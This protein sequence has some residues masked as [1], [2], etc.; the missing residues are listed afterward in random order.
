MAEANKT[1][2]RQQFLDSYTALVNGISTARFDEFKDFFA[3][4][5][6]FE[7]AV[8]EFRDGLQQELLAKVNRLWNECDIDTNVEILESLK[9]KAA[10]SS[11]KM[12]RPTGK[13]VSEQVRPLVVNKLKT[14]LKFYQLQLGFQKERTEELIYSIE[15]M[16]AKYRA[17]Q[18][19]RNHLLQQITN[20]QKTFD[21]I[22]AHH[23]ELEHKVNVDLQNCPNRK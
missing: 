15:T 9:S 5:N 20:E 12:W 3:N 18:T 1:T 17:M 4:E 11:N 2:A 8:Q 19:R 13:S 23:K 16:R 6:D 22:R 10:G 21:S 7:V 14:S